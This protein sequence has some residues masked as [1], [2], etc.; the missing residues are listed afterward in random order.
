MKFSVIIPLYNGEKFISKTLDSVICQTYK[1]YEIV[2][3]NDG[4][5]DNVG[6]TVKEYISDH[7]AIKFTYVEQKNRGL[8]GARNTA[9]RRASGEIMA[10]LDQ[11]DIWYPDKLEKVRKVYDDNPDADL[12]YHRQYNRKN[13]K[14]DGINGYE[15]YKNDLYKNLLFCGNILNTSTTTF[16]KSTIEKVGYF[17]EDVKNIH[18]TEDYDLWL[19]FALAGSRFYYLPDILGE[20]IIH[21]SNFFSAIDI[22]LKGQLYILDEH[23]GLVKD[24]NV[25]DWFRMKDRRAT[26]FFEAFE[27]YLF[28]A[29]KP[30]KALSCLIRTFWV[31]PF[32]FLNIINKAFKR[33]KRLFKGEKNR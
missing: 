23:Y 8:G 16:R 20:Y 10:L 6:K 33:I 1:D 30:L 3:V 14:I 12:V 13:G 28:E 18:F 22:I 19:R 9:I 5:P 25:F 15:L 7:P 32:F 2:L 24:R 29:R 17:S 11:D 21:G 26:L 31:D 27:R 4:S